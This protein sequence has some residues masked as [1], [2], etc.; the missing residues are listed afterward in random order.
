VLRT[1]RLF[2]PV[3]ESVHGIGS[4]IGFPFIARSVAL[5]CLSSIEIVPLNAACAYTIYDVSMMVL[6]DRLVDELEEN[7][8]SCSVERPE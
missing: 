8:C 1:H 3:F 4:L 6:Q 2:G 5:S 7:L